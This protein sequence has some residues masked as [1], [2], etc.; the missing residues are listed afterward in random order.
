MHGLARI[1]RTSGSRPTLLVVLILWSGAALLYGLSPGTVGEVFAVKVAYWASVLFTAG[2]LAYATLR[3]SW[4]GRVFWSLLLGGLLLRLVG[5]MSQSGLPFF[6]LLPPVVA[7]ND[8]AYAVSYALLFCALLW[9]TAHMTKNVTPLA[10]LDA[11]SIVISSG[12]LIWYFV[13]GPASAEEG[14]KVPGRCCGCSPG[15]YAMWGYSTWSS[16]RRPPTADP[17]LLTRFWGRQSSSWSR[18]GLGSG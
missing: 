18:R 13:L 5:E 16:L 2:A 3:V 17:P 10:S 6:N 14:W 15:R 12:L 11:L 7:L 1:M 9:L 4:A 8:V